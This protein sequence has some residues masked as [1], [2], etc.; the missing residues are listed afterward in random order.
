LTR[1]TFHDEKHDV[2]FP[3]GTFDQSKP[4]AISAVRTAV[5]NAP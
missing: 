1:I 3:A 5:K 4:L 2:E